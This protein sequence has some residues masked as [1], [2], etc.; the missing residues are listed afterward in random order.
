MKSKIM[1]AILAV[2]VCLLGVTA[3][4]YIEHDDHEHDNLQPPGTSCD[5]SEHEDEKEHGQEEQ[6]IELTAEEIQE[7]GL[8]TAVAGS[9][10]IDIH[11]S[12]TGEISVNQDRMAHIVPVVGGIVRQTNKKLGD[13]VKEGEVIAWLESSEL[14]KAKMNYL[15]KWAEMTCCSL[16]L[17]RAQKIQDST[18]KLLGILADSPSLETLQ[19]VNGIEMGDNLGKLISAYAEYSF[20]KAAYEREKLLFEQKISSE[21]DYLKTQN[22][23]KK[24][25]AQYNAA[26]DSISFEV[27]R[28]LLE[29]NRARQ[30]QSMQLKNAERQLKMMG[31]TDENIKEL[32][33]LAENQISI[34]AGEPDCDNPDCTECVRKKEAA[35]KS[36]AALKKAEERLAWYSLAAPFDGTI[37]E[38]HIVPG[39]LVGN[40]SSVYVVADLS[41]VWVDLQVYPKDLKYIKEGQKVTISAD[42]EI[43][44]ANGTISYVGPVVGAQSR[45]A[46]A[47]VI[48]D[49]SSGVFRP[50]LFVTALATVSETQAKVVVPKDTIQSLQGRKCVFIKDAHGFEPAFI[51]IGLENT[52]HAEILSGL[53]AGQEYVTKGTF[54]LKA[55]IVTS[56]FDSHAG[57]G[58]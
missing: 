54:A 18:V 2:V 22:A 42:S 57:H 40:E 15:G 56:T 39:E 53:A 48:L 25:F 32:E 10:T 49:N 38:K 41:S 45:T 21:E 26:R 4:L 12:L 16:D 23:F 1:I 35:N 11:I 28:T 55:K 29:A 20:A 5:N 43:P 50:G 31:L 30:L 14:G 8:E 34:P 51:E 7:I 24:A 47:R 17:T 46:L 36:T 44:K 13:A 3:T 37:I 9:G 58:H 52:N 19:N 33:L 6:A 27:K